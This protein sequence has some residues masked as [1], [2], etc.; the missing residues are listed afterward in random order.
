MIVGAWNLG[1]GVLLLWGGY[2]GKFVVWGT[3]SPQITLGLGAVM[4]V[5]GASQ[6]WRSRK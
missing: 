4:A 6:I 5:W 2:S 1:F 3:Q